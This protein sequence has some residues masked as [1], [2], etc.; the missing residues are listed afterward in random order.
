MECERD[1]SAQC[2][3]V[4]DHFVRAEHLDVCA[5]EVPECGGAG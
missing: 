3:W 5:T 1:G 2:G 4:D